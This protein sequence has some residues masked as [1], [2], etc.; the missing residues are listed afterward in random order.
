MDQR[1]FLH[2]TR[3]EQ[4]VIAL[5]REAMSGARTNFLG[6][7]ASVV[8][9]GSLASVVWVGSLA[10]VVW[11]PAGG[12]PSLERLLIHYQMTPIR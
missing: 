11:I 4:T 2:W 9:I 10:S 1:E 3:M 5:T 7:L 12:R 6:S 8:W